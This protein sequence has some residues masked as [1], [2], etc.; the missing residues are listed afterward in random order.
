MNSQL[1]LLPDQHLGIFVVYNSLGARDGG[2]T[3]QHMGFQRA[4]FDHYYPAAACRSNP[5]PN[6]LRRASQSVC[7]PLSGV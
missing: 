6:G 5:I 4:F 7:G 2:L 1:L 3:T